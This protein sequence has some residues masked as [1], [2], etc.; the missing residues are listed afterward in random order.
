[1]RARERT[2]HFRELKKLERIHFERR[3]NLARRFARARGEGIP[4][5]P[6]MGQGDRMNRGDFGGQNAGGGFQGGFG[7]DPERDFGGGAGRHG[8]GRFDGDPQ[9]KVRSQDEGGFG[10]PPAK[11]QRDARNQAPVI[12]EQPL[13]QEQMRFERQDRNEGQPD[14]RPRPAGNP[15]AQG[16]EDGGWF[17]IDE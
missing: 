15:S 14:P 8:L 12:D 3:Q 6:G 10:N 9:Q 13:P 4:D 2:V 7:Q 11:N 16:R 1:V 5:R 17:H